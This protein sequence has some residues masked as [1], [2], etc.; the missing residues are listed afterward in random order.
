MDAPDIDTAMAWRGRT[1]RDQDGTEL[2]TLRELYLDSQT[3]RP[4]WAGVKRGRLRNTETIVP[5]AG[6]SEID[7]D[8]VV[9][10]D[11]DRF[12]HAPDIDPDVELTEEQERALHEHYGHGWSEPDRDE[13]HDDDGAMIRSEEE[14]SVGKTARPSERVRL[15]KVIVEDEVTETV[16][17]RKE[18]IRLETDPPPEGRIESVEEIDDDPERGRA[19]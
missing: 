9:P 7:D 10:F 14:V 2:G 8:L 5:L 11:R 15:K 16:P 17:V 1:V 13:E 19:G 4:A 12:D 18:K 3:S 6:V